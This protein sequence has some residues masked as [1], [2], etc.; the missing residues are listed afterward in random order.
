[1]AYSKV[2]LNG[3]TLMDVTADT[4]ESN[5][6]LSAYTAHKN[7]GTSI[8]GNIAAK[9]SS[10]LTVSGATVTAPAGYYA[11][12]A[13]KSVASGIATSP[14]SISGSS[15]AVSTGTNTLTL[16]KTVSVTPNV[17]AGYIGSGT[18]GNSSVSLS[19]SVTTK[20]TATITP[21]KSTQTISSGTY[22]TGNQ[23]IS[24]IPDAYQDVT[25]VTATASDVASGK[26]FVDSTGDVVHGSLVVQHYYTGNGSPSSSM[27]ENGD[28]YFKSSRGTVSSHP[29]SYDTTDYSYASISTSYPIENAYTDSDSETQCQINLTTGYYAETYIYLNFD[30][31][32]IPA[33]A[34][35]VSVTAKTK[36]RSTETRTNYV[37]MHEAQLASGTTLKGSP[38]V[39]TET[40]TEETFADV[41]S[42]T[43]SEL[44]NACIRY[45]AKRGGSG[46]SASYSLRIYGATMTV[47]YMLGES[48]GTESIYYK[49]N[50]TWNEAA[51]VDKKVNGSWIE[52]TDLSQVIDPTKKLVKG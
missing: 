10:N 49:E 18:A 46:I 51:E 28:V 2:I 29:V 37:G 34:T 36:G 47:E 7:D 8:T 31:S 32:A 19:A 20:G 25:S 9:T 38:V 40:A 52:Q 23:T 50:G 13:S 12:N 33:D 14:A 3:T 44:Q 39:M 22:L 21:T 48:S 35:I 42:W 30:F 11:S 41:G 17:T 24:P 16:T 1:M 6:L 43:R 26:D 4:V 27:G 45:Y 5:R 15:A